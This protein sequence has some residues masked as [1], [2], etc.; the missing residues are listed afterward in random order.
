[1]KNIVSTILFS[2]VIVLSTFAQSYSLLDSKVG[3]EGKAA[4]NAYA[5]SGSVELDRAEFGGSKEALTTAEIVMDM[6]TIE[7]ENARLI[8]HLKSKDFFEVKRY[9]QA[10]FVMKSKL[11]LQEGKQEISGD[12]TI[13]GITHPISFPVELKAEGEKWLMAGVMA[14]DRTQYGITF[15]SPTYFEKLKDQAI[16]DEFELSFSLTLG[17]SAQAMR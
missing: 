5:L 4:F 3:W 14:I 13:K 6:R 15:N 9:E 12:L 17:Q 1:M 16:A 2:F 8:K 10:T 11:T 7:S